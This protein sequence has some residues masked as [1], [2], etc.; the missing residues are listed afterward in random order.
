MLRTDVPFANGG[1]VEKGEGD[2]DR[3]MASDVC[4]L[5]ARFWLFCRNRKYRS[6]NASVHGQLA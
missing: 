4:D 3:A 6:L 1:V 2:G 5:P